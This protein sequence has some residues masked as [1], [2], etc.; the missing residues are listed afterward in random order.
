MTTEKPFTLY[1]S[2]GV[3]EVVRGQT[4][5]AALLLAG[6]SSYSH[7][8]LSVYTEGDNTDFTWDPDE[9]AWVKQVEGESNN[10][11]EDSEEG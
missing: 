9:K 5:R 2:D 6:Y 3:R 8:A 7:G 4:I 11:N 1:W 10:G